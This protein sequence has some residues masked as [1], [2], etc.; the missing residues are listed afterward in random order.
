MTEARY[1]TER[2]EPPR[3]HQAACDRWRQPAVDIREETAGDVRSW[4]SR[5]E[6]TAAPP[7]SFGERL[8]ACWADRPGLVLDLGQLEY[9]SSAGFRVLLLAGKRADASESRLV[10]CGV[11][12]GAPALRHRRLPGPV[13]HR[14]VARG[15]DRQRPLR[16]SRRGP[17][18]KKPPHPRLRR[19][20][21]PPLGVTLA[22]GV[23]HAALVSIRLLFLLVAREAG[24]GPDRVLDVLAISMLVM[25]CSVYSRHCR[26]GRSAPATCAPGR[27][28]RPT[29]RRRSPPHAPAGS[30]SCSE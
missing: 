6:W 14:G 23:Q 9:I 7:L 4:R 1:T 22:C 30:A 27:T 16:A 21:T 5:A 29:S 24:L 25:A 2:P 15:G 17:A 18:V 12:E 28:P 13:Q 20:E 3:A 19:G 11:R 8:S 26:R 10:L